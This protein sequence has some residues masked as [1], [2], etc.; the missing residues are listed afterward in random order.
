[1]KKESKIKIIENHKIDVVYS[2]DQNIEGLTKYLLASGY[3]EEYHIE[4][5]EPEEKN[6][7]FFTKKIVIER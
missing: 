4:A 1:M 7:T 6:N 3:E 2:K 5:T